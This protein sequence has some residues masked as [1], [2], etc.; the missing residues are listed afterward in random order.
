MR[1]EQ[2][3]KIKK[4]LLKKTLKLTKIGKCFLKKLI[5]HIK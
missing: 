5:Y 1:L 2:L 3:L 4:M